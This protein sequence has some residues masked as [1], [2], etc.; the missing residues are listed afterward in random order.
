MANL[1]INDEIFANIKNSVI[2]ITGGSSGIGRSTA[3]LCLN[4]GATV[5]VGDLNAPDP[6]LENAEKFKFLNVNV[7]DWENLRSMFDE[8]NKLFGRIDHVFANAGVGP[9]TDFLDVT[10]DES[11]QLE[12]PNLRT[13]DIN[14]L[15]PIYTARLASAYMSELASQR[16]EGAGGSIV[17]A[18]SAS[19][20][21]NFSAGDYTIA[22]HGVLGMIRG[23]R[24]ALECDC[25]L[26]DSHRDSS[27]DI[28]K[29]LN[30]GVQSPEVVAQS[31]VL[32]FA[33]PDRHGEV[34]YSWEGHYRE[35]NKTDGGLLA[36]AK[37][38]LENGDNEERVM[39]K[40]REAQLYHK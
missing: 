33:D 3:Q 31:V 29:S 12:P 27:G 8:A 35:V 23:E 16:P 32:L 25:T 24:F 26:L 15:G 22:K 14:L 11:G 37:A 36:S 38:I 20:F 30:A 4:L 18:A 28:L 5:V 19:S 6:E 39:I 13:I 10:L 7:T 17:L 1:E 2:L 9:T 40:L 34:I 21:Q